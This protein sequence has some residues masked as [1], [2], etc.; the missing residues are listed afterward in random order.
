MRLP[1]R[2]HV[3]TALLTQVRDFFSAFIGHCNKDFKRFLGVLLA[4]DGDGGVKNPL[5]SPYSKCKALL[6]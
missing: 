6:K 1:V 5:A 2:C 4:M 3:S